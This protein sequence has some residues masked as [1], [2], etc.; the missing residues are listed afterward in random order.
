VQMLID[1]QMCGYANVQM[2]KRF[3]ILESCKV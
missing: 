3:D 2:L 1:V